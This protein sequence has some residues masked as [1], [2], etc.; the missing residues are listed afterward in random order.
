MAADMDIEMDLDVGLMDEDLDAIKDETVPE[1]GTPLTS[2]LDP[3][4]W[5]AEIAL[6]KSS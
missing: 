6:S 5:L 3:E 2:H 4:S 1:V